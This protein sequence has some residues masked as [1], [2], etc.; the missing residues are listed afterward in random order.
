MINAIFT[1]FRPSAV[2]LKSTALGDSLFERLVACGCFVARNVHKDSVLQMLV[3]VW[4]R[5]QNV[6]LLFLGPLG[7]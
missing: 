2:L 7:K 3:H 1:A 5:F 4:Q 6:S